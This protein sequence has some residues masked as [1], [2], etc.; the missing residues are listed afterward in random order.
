MKK[1]FHLNNPKNKKK[2]F[3]FKRDEDINIRKKKSF[4][5]RVN[6]YELQLLII[7]APRA[8][9]FFSF[10]FFLLSSNNEKDAN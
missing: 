2:L 3:R 7:I 4:F 9:T 6:F 5:T 1:I 10:L 8:Q